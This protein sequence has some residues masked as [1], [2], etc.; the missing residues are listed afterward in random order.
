MGL[1][2]RDGFELIGSRPTSN[3]V[4]R[5]FLL[6]AFP[7]KKFI[8][9]SYSCH[10]LQ[11]KHIERE[12]PL[13]PSAVR[14]GI[15]SNGRPIRVLNVA[16]KPSVAKAVAGILSRNSGLRVRDGRS[17]YNRIFEFDYTIRSQPCHM[18]VTSVTGH[19]MELKFEDRFRK[20]HSCDAADLYSAPVCKFVPQVSLHDDVPTSVFVV[21]VSIAGNRKCIEWVRHSVPRAPKVRSYPVDSSHVLSNFFAIEPAHGLT[22]EWLRLSNIGAFTDDKLDIKRTLEDEAKYC[23][24]LVLWLDCDREGENIAFEVMEVCTAANNRLEIWRAR[25]SALIDREIHYAVQNLARPNQ[26]FAD[27]VDARQF[28]TLGFVV[29]RYWEIQSHEP[30]DFWTINC[31][32][33]SDDG[34]ATFNWMRGHL[35]D[36]TCAVTI[37]EMCVEEPTATV[38]KVRNQEKLKYPPHPLSTIELQKRASRYFRMSSE[39][40]MKLNKD[41]NE[42]QMPP[43]INSVLCEEDQL[44]KLEKK[45]TNL[46]NPISYCTSKDIWFSLGG[47]PVINLTNAQL[48]S[49]SHGVAS[50]KWNETALQEASWSVEAM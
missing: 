26:L 44:L 3:N 16:E 43:K 21:V 2:G 4:I 31:S 49:T 39:Q 18:L 10:F 6:P 5:L 42:K 25:F 30:E 24:W 23:Q 20:W 46:L 15:M 50:R 40:T 1:L 38:A 19:L 11:K 14:R 12:G 13:R 34:S 27:A 8:S 9:P 28:P 32:H 33:T 7:S 41:E 37:Y 36:Y 35:F 48:N 47:D 45:R 17:R 29:E 22:I